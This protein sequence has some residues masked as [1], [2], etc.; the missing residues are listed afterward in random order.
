MD[1]SVIVYTGSVD[2]MHLVGCPRNSSYCQPIG[3]YGSRTIGRQ[4]KTTLSYLTHKQTS[5]KQKVVVEIVEANL[6]KRCTLL[7]VQFEKKM[8][9][10]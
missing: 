8:A 9:T 2:W 3:I 4:F 10:M 7:S 1:W 6:T 5:D